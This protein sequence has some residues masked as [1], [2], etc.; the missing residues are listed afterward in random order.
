[1][2]DVKDIVFDNS[3]TQIYFEGDDKHDYSYLWQQSEAFINAFFLAICILEA[4]LYGKTLFVTNVDKYQEKLA[5][6]IYRV[7]EKA[8]QETRDAQLFMS[9]Y[10]TLLERVFAKDEQ[11]FRPSYKLQSK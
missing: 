2:L 7:F 6:R 5:G 9:C 3:A 10:P 8:T 1:M 11:V 4:V